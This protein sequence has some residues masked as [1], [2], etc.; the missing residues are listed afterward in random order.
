[1]HEISIDYVEQLE[2][3]NA[4]LVERLEELTRDSI[5]R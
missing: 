1:M 5:E 2:Q 3:Q 4:R